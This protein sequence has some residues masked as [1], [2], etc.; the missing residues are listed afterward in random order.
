MRGVDGRAPVSG[1]SRGMT[2]CYGVDA[3]PFCRPFSTRNSWPLRSP[4]CHIVPRTQPG[5]GDPVSRV[6]DGD[7]SPD[8]LV[9]RQQVTLD[10]PINQCL[11]TPACPIMAPCNV[12]HSLKE[13]QGVTIW[14]RTC[15]PTLASRSGKKFEKFGGRPSARR[16]RPRPCHKQR[17]AYISDLPCLCAQLVPCNTAMTSIATCQSPRL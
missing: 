12:R 13:Y 9:R 4:V 2:G 5:S 1:K 7:C 6:A 8:H 15:P 16:N 3:A 11:A 14:L 17:Y 10:L